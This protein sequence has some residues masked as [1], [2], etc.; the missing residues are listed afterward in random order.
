[1]SLS[2]AWSIRRPSALLSFSVS[3]YFDLLAATLSH[4]FWSRAG[5]LCGQV[6]IVC[7]NRPFFIQHGRPFLHLLFSSPSRSPFFH[8]LSQDGI[9][10]RSWRSSPYAAAAAL[11]SSLLRSLSTGHTSTGTAR[12][13]ASGVPDRQHPRAV[14]AGLPEQLLL[15]FRSEMYL[16]R[17]RKWRVMLSVWQRVL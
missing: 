16:Y 13:G 3:I 4:A 15:P 17:Q 2:S 9:T 14:R 5:S 6:S 1:M 11:R 10:E 8:A 12:P 7:T